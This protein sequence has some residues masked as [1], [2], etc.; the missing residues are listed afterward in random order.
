MLQK[1]PESAKNT[2]AAQ[3][4]AAKDSFAVYKEEKR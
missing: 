1:K 4:Y 2:S 3:C